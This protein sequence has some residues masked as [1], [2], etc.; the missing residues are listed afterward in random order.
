MQCVSPILLKPSYRF[1]FGLLVPCGHCVACRICR[2]R[3]WAM[4]ITHESAYWQQ[5]VFL[6][7]TYD[8]QYLPDNYTL[9][10]EHLQLFWKRVRKELKNDKI[11]Y[12]ACG[13][14][15]EKKGRPH[16]HAIVFSN[17]QY[18]GQVLAETWHYGYTHIDAVTYNSA[19]YVAQYI[20][21]KL[22]GKMA[23]DAYEKQN[24]EAPFQVSSNGFGLRYAIDYESDI[25][26]SLSTRCK[27]KDVGL[28]RY[29]KKKLQIKPDDLMIKARELEV[30]KIKKIRD[31]LKK[32][33]CGKKS[34]EQKLI[35]DEHIERARKQREAELTH[36]V[37]NRSSKL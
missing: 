3:E 37:K 36:R 8:N 19:R 25:K 27:G 31:R 28:P 23:I 20:D 11:K 21:K 1:P 10:K 26:A 14:Y 29:Y 17:Y 12:H 33:L 7:L 32:Q 4:R 16:Y 22:S 2:A 18:L 6:T 13:E 35:I 30:K 15:G 9:K 34:I 5:A 24:R